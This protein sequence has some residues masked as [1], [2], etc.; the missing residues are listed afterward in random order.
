M[1]YPQTDWV[2][3]YGA[4]SP[5][6]NAQLNA[7][8]SVRD[9]LLQNYMAQMAAVGAQ[10]G[11]Q[12]QMYA[13]QTIPEQQAPPP[14]TLEWHDEDLVG[15]AMYW[16]IP[17]EAARAMPKEALVEYV[18]SK[19]LETQPDME[20]LEGRLAA[21]PGVIASLPAQ[22]GLGIAQAIT[23]GLQRLPIIGEAF[24]R[25]EGLRDADMWLRQLEEGVRASTPANTQGLQTAAEATGWM[26]TMWHPGVLAWNGAGRIAQTLPLVKRFSP[27]SRA[28]LQGGASVY[29]LEGG[30]P[31]FEDHPY[32][33][34]GAGVVLG[35]VG[36]RLEKPIAALAGRMQQKFV[37][38]EIVAA[39]AGDAPRSTPVS[40]NPADEQAARIA[41]LEAMAA[42]G[43]QQAAEILQYIRRPA[44]S[45]V[46][47]EGPLQ[48]PA[49]ASDEGFNRAWA[50]A[51]ARAA[52]AGDDVNDPAMVMQHFDPAEAETIARE[53]ANP[54]EEVVAAAWRIGDEVV[55]G[56]QYSHGEILDELRRGDEGEYYDI[57]H[58]IDD[59]LESEPG[60]VTSSGR[61]VTM[62][63]AEDLALRYAPPEARAIIEA[64]RAKG[65]YGL[66][67]ID[68]DR[69][70]GER[71]AAENLAAQMNKV[72]IVMDSPLMPQIAGQ[73]DVDAVSVARAADASNPGGTNLVQGIV[74]PQQFVTNLGS[75][76]M[77]FVR[78][79]DRTDVL[80][81]DLPIQPN[82]VQDYEKFGAYVGQRVLLPDGVEGTI[83]SIAKNGIAT[84]E[85]VYAGAPKR[86]GV[87]KLSPL[88]ESPG[89]MDAEPLWRAFQ[90]YSTQRAA[91]SAEAM[92][93]GLTIEKVTSL[94]NE[95][96][97]QYVDDFLTD[98]AKLDNPA[99]KARAESYFNQR[100][101]D[102]FRSV[103]P[104]Q[105]ARQEIA[106]AEAAAVMERVDLP[107]VQ[108]LDELAM[109]KGYTA[110]PNGRGGWELADN[111]GNPGSRTRVTFGSLDA[112][113]TWLRNFNRDLPDITPNSDVPIELQASHPRVAQQGPNTNE[114]TPRL[115]RESLRELT[116]PEPIAGGSLTGREAES[117][118]LSGQ[119]GIVAGRGDS[120]AGTGTP[121]GPGN[122]PP[123]G[124]DVDPDNVGR[125]QNQW[126]DGFSK[127]QPA[128]RFWSKI[129]NLLHE[130]GMPTGLAADTERLSNLNVI[131]N[132]EMHPLFDELTDIMK[133]VTKTSHLT[134][135]TWA[136]IYEIEDDVARLAAARAAGFTEREIG[137]LDEA[138]RLMQRLFPETG[139]DEIRQ[140]PRYFSHIAKRQ[141]DPSM[142]GRAYDDFPLGETT[143]PFYEFARTGNLNLREM[144][145]RIVFEA[146]IRSVFW[147][148]NMARPFNE[149]VNKWKALSETK[150][151]EPVATVMENWL[152]IFRYGY[153]ADD[154]LALD[155]LHGV[156][157]TAGLKVSRQQAKELFNFGLNSTHAGLLGFR[158]H[159]MARDAL[160]LMFAIPRAGADLADVIFRYMTNP[161]FRNTIWEEAVGTGAV[162][163]QSPRMAAPGVIE[164]GFQS[165]TQD[166]SGRL[167]GGLRDAVRELMPETLR[168]SIRDTPL[169]PMYFYGKQGEL[170]R[171]LVYAAGKQKTARALSKFRA[172]GSLDELMGE[173]A[174]R[175]FDPSWQRQFQEIVASGDD[176]AAEQFLGRQLAD[177]TQFKYG[178]LESP[179]V[180]KSLTGRLAMQFGNYSM[181]YFQ[182]L[183]E[184]LVNGTVTDKAKFLL[185]AGAVTAGLEAATRET[186]WNFRW[187]NPYFGLGF[188]GGPWLSLTTDVAGG[189]SSFARE[190]QTGQEPGPS[191]YRD[192][193][194]AFG[195]AASFLNPVAGL[196]RTAQGLGQAMD[197]PMPLH[198]VGRLLVTGE[199]GA[200]PDVNAA[201]LPQAEEAFQRS[202]Q[203]MQSPVSY[204]RPGTVE[205]PRQVASF[206]TPDGWMPQGA[207]FLR[208]P[209]QV[210]APGGQAYSY[211]LNPATTPSEELLTMAIAGMPEALA[212]FDREDQEFLLRL[213][214][215]PPDIRKTIWSS[216]Q[217][218]KVASTI[219]DRP[220]MPQGA[221]RTSGGGGAQ[222]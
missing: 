74:D 159:V 9:R 151:L 177:A 205:I 70:A 108:Q 104:E 97:S 10:P 188:T 207:G 42:A 2:G 89:T 222:Y 189:I 213:S 140:I 161:A 38:P 139:L 195:Q 176:T 95:N 49:T 114:S 47:P 166:Q 103:A 220:A 193:N 129:D 45:S 137:T 135:G 51:Q 43:D 15:A 6:Y 79:G 100:F 28:A 127:W 98:I 141:S 217:Q 36:A 219:N 32:L 196:Y 210:P 109:T 201:F 142:A 144:D 68:L 208:A 128:R 54:S 194:Q 3:L 65:S 179:W 198:A 130:A 1:T 5:Q 173:S 105:A 122:V 192:F 202:L 143:R 92:P 83:R 155:T 23:G 48:G 94:L 162:A 87:K 93:G 157:A 107:P 11:I 37:S 185:T 215:V 52:A 212:Q 134:D 24:S 167:A 146:Y 149:T 16:G 136:R 55:E 77:A 197:S 61:F 8:N 31:E 131:N 156:M 21:I 203:P 106:S 85:P 117:V 66:D 120:A 125:L 121:A 25:I 82:M 152:K 13:G 164:E 111:I 71:Q 4:G 101:V 57:I 72:S 118:T 158:L 168:G 163:L 116:E 182:Y 165:I 169:H 153:N 119:P 138:N 53:L 216:Y 18:N 200:G 133:K 41:R 147:Q 183:R 190:A 204:T 214:E 64:R 78:R 44:P 67:S 80:L 33:M 206:P 132:N 60:F 199:R 160:Q 76:F 26:A 35:A 46:I 91:A 148:K 50:N 81:S 221:P 58:R 75:K 20:T 187:M 178:Q 123:A 99:D 126:F 112:A 27:I 124:L 73:A 184:S 59:T 69:I 29:A 113:E 175:T 115:M 209:D 102:D 150:E 62:Y 154:D 110:I 12:P 90:Q 186:G 34:L 40:V 86:L 84:V 170:M 171:A 30:S 174:A 14:A 211:R 22:A 19:R 63:E 96:R 191:T 39:A 7:F 180:A 218:A 145:P 17:Q 88:T 181:Q 56:G 172:G